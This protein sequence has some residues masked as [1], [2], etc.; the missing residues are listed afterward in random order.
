MHTRQ[1]SCVYRAQELC[2]SRG[3]RPGLPVPNRLYGLSGRQAKLKKKK[4][5]LRL[6]E[7]MSCVKFE[8][9]VLGSASL[10]VR[11]ISVDDVKQQ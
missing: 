7:L 1:N 11:T 2:E 10:I 9:D 3:G 4:E 8:V 6:T 5:T